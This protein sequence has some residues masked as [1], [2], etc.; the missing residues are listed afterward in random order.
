[1][2]LSIAGTGVTRLAGRGTGKSVSRT[3]RDEGL[4]MTMEVV[5]VLFIRPDV[6]AVKVRQI[7]TSSDGHPSEAE[8][9]FTPM[10][11]MA[12]EDEQ[13]R[14]VACQNTGVSG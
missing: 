4:T 2:P 12:K 14:L 6:A 3:R 5:H 9:E 10:F 13:W 1:M 7:Y 11:V 8:G